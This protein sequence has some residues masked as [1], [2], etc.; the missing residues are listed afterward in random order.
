M[1]AVEERQLY[2]IVADELENNKILRGTWLKA[3]AEALGDEELAES[4][5]VKFRVEELKVELTKFKV[6]QQPSFGE[7]IHD[8]F[9]SVPLRLKEAA[10]SGDSEAQLAA[11]RGY[12]KKQQWEDSLRYYKMI[13]PRSKEILL[14]IS[15]V[16]LMLARDNRRRRN[17]DASLKYFDMVTPQDTTLNREKQGMCIDAYNDLLAEN[18]KAAYRFGLMGGI[19]PEV[20]TRAI[21]NTMI[22]NGD[23]VRAYM[24]V[25]KAF[26]KDRSQGNHVLLSDIARLLSS[27]RKYKLAVLSIEKKVA[28][29]LGNNM[30]PRFD[31]QKPKVKGI[32]F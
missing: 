4:L 8:A 31:S 7:I 1:N 2:E 29:F 26:Y 6:K 10:M 14:E 5:Y 3:M 21:S 30:D 22:A 15:E 16:K 11:A 19:D 27:D 9:A 13:D 25:F 23:L 18:P 17:W 24:W 28:D 12:K 20:I 32:F